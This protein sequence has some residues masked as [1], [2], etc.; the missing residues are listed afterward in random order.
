MNVEERAKELRTHLL[1]LN[2]V[3]FGDFAVEL[4]LLDYLLGNKC[5]YELPNKS[6]VL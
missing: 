5:S 6:G 2:E 3:N 4:D 1:A